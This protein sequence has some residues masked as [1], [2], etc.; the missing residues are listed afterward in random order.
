MFGGPTESAL[1]KMA[2]DRIGRPPAAAGRVH[3]RP[4]GRRDVDVWA[5]SPL[6]NRLQAGK[7]CEWQPCTIDDHGAARGAQPKSKSH[8]LG[9]HHLT[10]PNRVPYR[11]RG[12]GR[13]LPIIRKGAMA[14][15]GSPCPPHSCG[16]RAVDLPVVLEVPRGH[17]LLEGGLGPLVL[18]V[19]GQVLAHAL[20]AA[21]V[22]SKPEEDAGDGH[23]APREEE[24][25][26][27]V[28][29]PG[30]HLVVHLVPELVSGEGLGAKVGA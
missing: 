15:P 30:L 25:L 19:G 13:E 16:G 29:H 4:T 6:Y 2:T 5:R 20:E 11:A 21:K 10:E 3:M 17:A 27:G 9:G 23:A 24:A 8:A 14:G 1:L 26:G 7:R 12:R 18:E 28:L 22:V